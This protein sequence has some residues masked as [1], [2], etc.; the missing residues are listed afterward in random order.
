MI[1]YIPENKPLPWRHLNKDCERPISEVFLTLL[2]HGMMCDLHFIKY[3][4]VISLFQLVE[5]HNE[6]MSV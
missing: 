3:Y 2:S 1:K 6:F 4:L 5:N